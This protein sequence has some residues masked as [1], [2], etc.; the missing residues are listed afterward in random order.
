MGIQNQIGNKLVNG[1]KSFLTSTAL[2]GIIYISDSSNSIGVLPVGVNGQ[3]L[4]VSSGTPTWSNGATPSGNAGGDLTGTYPSPT[5]ATSAVTYAK[6]QNVS[7]TNRILGRITTGAGV[8]EELTGGNVASI[9]GLGTAAYVNTGTSS[10]NVPILDSGGKLD[11]NVIPALRSHE[12]YEVANQAARL[13]LTTSQVQPGDTVYQI[14]TNEYYI[15]TTTDPTLNA[16]WRLL[17]DTSIDAALITSGTIATARL[18][19]G[20]ANSTTVLFGDQTYKSVSSF[21][22]FVWNTVSGTT[23]TMVANNGYVVTNASLTTL[24]LPTTAAINTIIEVV[25]NGTGGWKIAQNTGQQIKLFGTTAGTN[26]ST[27]GLTGY[28][29]AGVVSGTDALSSIKLICTTANTTWNI[30]SVTGN[31]NFN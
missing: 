5:I 30:I 18:G 19:N 21:V 14:D 17:A 20:T 15:L 31:V 2:G 4:V 12:Y 9:L 23:Q 16:N 11:V 29:D 22:T 25:G 8:I 24:T 28:I 6:I 27:V 1:L 7:A 3:V 13:A 26:A 10:G